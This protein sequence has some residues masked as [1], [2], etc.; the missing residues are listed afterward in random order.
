MGEAA[1]RLSCPSPP[2]GVSGHR[3]GHTYKMPRRR[4]KATIGTCHVC[5]RERPLSFEHIPPRAAFNVDKVD[6]G[7]LKHWLERNNDGKRLRHA[8]QQGGAG[9]SRL[10]EDCNSR[11][12]S[13]YAAELTGW[14]HAAVAAIHSLPSVAEMDAQLEDH[15][16]MFRI[17]GVRPLAMVKQIVTMV[18]VV[19]DVEFAVRRSDLRAFVLDRDRTGLRDIEVYLALYLGP[20]VRFVGL[21]GRANLE[22]GDAF[23]LS[24]VAYPP[25]SYIASFEEPPPMLR[26][27]NITGFAEIPYT[28]R[29]TAEIELM[30]GFGHTPLPA[31]LRTGAQVERDREEN[32]ADA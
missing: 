28:S 22:T 5:L 17:E 27:G 23:V 11:T 7:G 21:S 15:S 9:F 8:I 10:C 3:A 13:W 26:V 2:V 25:F 31:D 14:V 32:T 1:G 29:A 18:L 30:V 20:M 19:N 4:S 24:E 12:G 6:I 16:V